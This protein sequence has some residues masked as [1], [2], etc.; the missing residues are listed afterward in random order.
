MIRKDTM[1]YNPSDL[2]SASYA[3]GAMGA[4]NNSGYFIPLT[5]HCWNYTTS[6]DLTDVE[7]NS[8]FSPEDRVRP[9]DRVYVT[10]S[11]GYGVYDVMQTGL[12]LSKIVTFT[13][14]PIYW[15]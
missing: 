9:T 15:Q 12:T 5:A 7:S 10:A 4:V 11:D 13:G 14:T 1:A 3:T 2:T 8:Y 6:D